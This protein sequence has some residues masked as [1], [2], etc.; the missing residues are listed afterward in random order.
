MKYFWVLVSLIVL[1]QGV[2]NQED[3]TEDE[4][5]GKQEQNSAGDEPTPSFVPPTTP[6]GDVYFTESFS[7]GIEKWVKSEA[8][9]DDGTS[10]YDGR[11]VMLHATPPLI[12][13]LSVC[14]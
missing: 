4:V 9:K 8:K 6:S 14:R 7:D 3:L 5:L 13:A 12:S 11:T 1:L 10:R 2:S